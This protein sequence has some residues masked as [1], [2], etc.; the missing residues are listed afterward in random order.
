MIICLE[1]QSTKAPK[2]LQPEATR[3]KQPV[4]YATRSIYL[5]SNSPIKG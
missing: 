4:L 5:V 3:K 1:P 2:V